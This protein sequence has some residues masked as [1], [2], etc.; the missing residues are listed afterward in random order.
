M[1]RSKKMT[2]M[3][4]F[5]DYI[6]ILKDF[7]IFF[8]LRFCCCCFFME[9]IWFDCS[10]YMWQRFNIVILCFNNLFFFFF[11]LISNLNAFLLRF[12]V[13]R[14]VFIC[15]AIFDTLVGIENCCWLVNGVCGDNVLRIIRQDQKGWWWNW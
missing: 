4:N 6:M 9:I 10:W 13:N 7:S 12:N 2:K 14:R 11:F 5:N 8:L 1:T 3:H 15:Y